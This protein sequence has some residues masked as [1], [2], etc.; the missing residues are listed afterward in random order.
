MGLR[1]H[2]YDDGVVG[3]TW[4]KEKDSYITPGDHFGG[5]NTSINWYV[6]QPHG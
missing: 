3:V 1:P 6:F 5:G 4:V 2:G